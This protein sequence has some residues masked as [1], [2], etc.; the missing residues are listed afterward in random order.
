MAIELPPSVRQNYHPQ[1]EDA[2]N[3]HI[4]LELHASF[5]YLAMSF[6]FDQN[7]V[8]LEN[9]A[10]LF[11][12]QSQ[13]KEELAK[14][15]MKLQ[16]LRG[17]HLRQHDIRKP[18]YDD[19]ESGLKALECAFH[20]EKTLN[21][22]LLALHRVATEKKDP[23]LCSFLESNFLHQQVKAIKQLSDYITDLRKMGAPDT[24]LADYLFDKLTL[25]N[26]DKN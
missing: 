2:V 15:L 1:C 8:A 21:Q 13:R 14:Q 26:S 6:Y 12:R 7:D 16:N 4:N 20:L 5:V 11:L 22:S 25:G 10:Q 9:F 19:W 23:H 17:G 18:D 3:R 24:S